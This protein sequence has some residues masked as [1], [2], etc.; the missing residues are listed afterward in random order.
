M[1]TAATALLLFTGILPFPVHA[2]TAE[3][4]A[5]G[6]CLIGQTTGEDRLLLARWI[7]LA[8]ASHPVVQDVIAVDTGK[9]A[10]TDVAM[11]ELVTALVTERCGAQARAAVAAEGDPSIAMQKA[12]EMLG[13]VASQE[14]MQNPAA[15]ERI[16][17]FASHLDASRLAATLAP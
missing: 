1:R 15:Q 17:A 2:T 7:T 6:Q 10:E 8:F 11:A 5:F 9:L 13:A 16:N 3:T 4:E 12:F 14:V